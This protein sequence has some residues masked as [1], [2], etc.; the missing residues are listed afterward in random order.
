MEKLMGKY[1]LHTQDKPSN[2]EK[3]SFLIDS[4]LIS[5]EKA[6]FCYRQHSR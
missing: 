5:K 3:Q 1:S 4:L 2:K 6:I